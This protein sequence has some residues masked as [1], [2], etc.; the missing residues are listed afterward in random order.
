MLNFIYNVYK[1]I[2]YWFFCEEYYYEYRCYEFNY[3]KVFKV[4]ER[5]GEKYVLIFKDE[6]FLEID[7]ID[8]EWFEFKMVYI[9]MEGK[10]KMKIF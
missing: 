7:W 4:I 9:I 2:V 10:V 5:L 1:L 8:C 3:I 6:W